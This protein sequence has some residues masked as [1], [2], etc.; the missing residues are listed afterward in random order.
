MAALAAAGLAAVAALAWALGTVVPPPFSSVLA[1]VVVGLLATELLKRRPAQRALRMFH[2]YF[3]ARE[4]G[5]DEAAARSRLVTRLGRDR[6]PQHRLSPALE[7]GWVGESERDRVLGGVA[8]LLAQERRRVDLETLGRLYDRARDRFTI[9]GWDA[10]PKEFVGELQRRLASSDLQRLDAL[11]E[12]YRLFHQRFFRNSVSLGV[13]PAAGVADLA[14]LLQSLGNRLARDGIEDALLAYRL[15]LALRPADNL[16]R[17]GLALLLDRAGRSRE[18]A[19]EAGLALGALDGH[20][21]HAG[22]DLTLEDL[23][24][25]RKRDDLRQALERIAMDHPSSPSE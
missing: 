20:T 21:R 6:T 5:A 7:A 1:I 17:A 2:A 23:F 25:Y 15:S 24:P 11:A 8:A 12:K 9:P 19:P 22:G 3:R 14:R 16:A 13:D 4:R 10:L 18:A